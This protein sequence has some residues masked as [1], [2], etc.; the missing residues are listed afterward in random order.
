[1]RSSLRRLW[2]VPEVRLV[3]AAFVLDA[4]WELLQSPLYA[5]HDRG[6]LY[7]LRTRLHCTAGDVLI[8]LAVFLLTSLAFRSR[9]WF[10]I[11]RLLPRA[12]FVV[13]G[14][15]YTTFSEWFNTRVALAWEYAPAMPRILGVGLLPLLQWIIIP[16]VLLAVLRRPPARSSARS[17]RGGPRQHGERTPLARGVGP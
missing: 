15:S 7:L 17:P 5:D 9:Y 8:S 3:G 11:P 2:H 10:L 14:L 12:V 6:L 16:L 1:M 13:G 4:I